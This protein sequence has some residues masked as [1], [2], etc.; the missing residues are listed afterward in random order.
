MTDL[1]I[2]RRCVEAMGYKPTGKSAS[3]PAIQ[4]EGK[5]HHIFAFDP[6]HDDAQAME[7]VK[8][9]ALNCRKEDDDGGKRH[10]WLVSEHMGYITGGNG[11]IAERRELNRAICECVAEMQKAKG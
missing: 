4:V 6:L 7:L 3:E 1:E 11:A 5:R 9:L 8:K 2:T 10:T